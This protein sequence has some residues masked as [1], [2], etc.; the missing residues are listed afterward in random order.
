MN[1]AM[2][3]MTASTSFSSRTFLEVVRSS[4]TET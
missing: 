3:I 2:Q 1:L 4:Y